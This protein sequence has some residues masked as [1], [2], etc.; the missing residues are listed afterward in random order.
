MSGGPWHR[1]CALN[2]LL[3]GRSLLLLLA[4]LRAPTPPAPSPSVK[5]CK[6]NL[7]Q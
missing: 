2:P 4:A 1:G 6:A 7:Q 3:E 5:V